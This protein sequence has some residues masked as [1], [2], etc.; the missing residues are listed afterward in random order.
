MIANSPPVKCI[1]ASSLVAWDGTSPEGRLPSDH[2]ALSE[3]ALLSSVVALRVGAR[4]FLNLLEYAR[5]VN[6]GVTAS[7]GKGKVLEGFLELAILISL[8]DL[9]T[10]G[11]LQVLW[12]VETTYVLAL[13]ANIIV[14]IN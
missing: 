10:W 9:D 5:T 6:N 1:K 14:L 4:L 8:E 2:S 7:D 13:F 12:V 3:I 11:S